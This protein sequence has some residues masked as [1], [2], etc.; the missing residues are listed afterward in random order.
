M[1]EYR[2]EGFNGYAV[3]YSPFFD[4]RLAVAAAANFGL[5]GNGRFYILDLTP[6]GIVPLKWY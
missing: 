4:S 5:V 2:T 1:L 3:K 6:N